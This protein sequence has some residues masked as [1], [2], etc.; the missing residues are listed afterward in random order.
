VTGILGGWVWETDAE[1][2]FV[3]MSPS[4]ERYAGK[5]PEWHYG[6]TRQELGNTSVSTA[7]G[8]PWTEQLAAR[9]PFGPVDFIRYQDGH[10]LWMRTMGEPQFDADGA[11]TGYIGIAFELPGEETSERVDRRGAPRRRIVR[12]AE[13]RA[14]E[15]TGDVACVLSDISA[16]GAR[17]KV[18]QGVHLPEQFR[19]TVHSLSMDRLCELRWR[20]DG[21][22]GVAFVD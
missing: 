8:C 7:D 14:V 11:F 22:I 21:E 5:P 3:Y 2:R 17:L 6:K 4:V 13:I 10:A 20:G 9:E 12:A 15:T 16:T 19:L 1:H 18:P